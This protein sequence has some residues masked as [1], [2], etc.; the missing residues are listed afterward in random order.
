MATRTDRLL[1]RE[2]FAGGLRVGEG[3]P[4]RLR[5]V[6]ALPAGDGVV[7][8]APHGLLVVPTGVNPDT[9]EPAFAAPADGPVQHLRWAAFT[10]HTSLS[11]RAGFDTVEGQ[12]LT[13]SAEVAV[14][15]FGLAHHPYD[16]VGDPGSDIRLGAA[17]LI[18][19]DLES[20]IVF[21]FFMT[22]DRV[23]AVYERLALKPGVQFAA[24]TYAVPVA[25][26]EADQTHHLEVT[27]DRA[28]ATAHWRVDGTPVLSVD[29]IGFRALDDAYLKRDNGLP[30][31]A[32]LPRQLTY[33]MGL[34]ADR[35]YGQGIELAVR[36]LQV[37]AAP[38]K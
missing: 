6:D 28:A 19:V 36:W 15:G 32:V 17:G 9:G 20:G 8:A 26:R 30:E 4:W 38:K 5:P 22:N 1:F 24:F 11:G 18:S 25:D 33:G 2:D 23:Y 3:A 21:D 16:D 35:M 37:S 29:R 13:V 31:E 27:F 10:T 12:V 34:F 7:R 14:L